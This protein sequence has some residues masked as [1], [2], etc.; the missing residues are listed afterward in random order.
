MRLVKVRLTVEIE[1]TR[2]DTVIAD[3]ALPPGLSRIVMSDVFEKTVDGERTSGTALREALRIDPWSTAA[4]LSTFRIAS[5]VSGFI[6]N[7]RVTANTTNDR[8]LETRFLRP[9]ISLFMI[10][11]LLEVEY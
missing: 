1:P 6:V 3:C 4:A 2:P 11:Y 7:E 10:A 8:I 9:G 5:I